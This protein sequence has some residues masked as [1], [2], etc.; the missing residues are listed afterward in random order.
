MLDFWGVP[1]VFVDSLEGIFVELPGGANGDD[2]RQPP[3]WW[4][5]APFTR[6]MDGLGHA[7]SGGTDSGY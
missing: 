5:A 2:Q 1:A 7:G 3:G 6:T 4:H